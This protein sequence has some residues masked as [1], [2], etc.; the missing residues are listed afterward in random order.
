MVL[1]SSAGGEIFPNDE[2]ETQ[3]GEDFSGKSSGIISVEWEEVYTDARPIHWCRRDENKSE[4]YR[5]RSELEPRIK[6]VSRD[7]SQNDGE[8]QEIKGEEKKRV[9]EMLIR[10]VNP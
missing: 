9:C 2:D 4:W 7:E 8:R 6:E 5:P 10:L 3:S 1:P